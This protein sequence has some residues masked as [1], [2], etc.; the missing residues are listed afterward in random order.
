MPAPFVIRHDCI[1]LDACCLIN[2]HV[3]GHIQE[4][5]ECVPK[6]VA[7]AAYVKEREIKRF[8]LDSLI[9][10]KRIRVVNPTTEAEYELLT[11][12]AAV[13]DDG[14]AVTGAIALSRN[15]AI[16]TDDRRAIEVIRSKT[17]K[18]QIVSSLELIKNWMDQK[19]ESPLMIQNV[20]I[21]LKRDANYS[22][23]H[24]HEL[25]TWWKTHVVHEK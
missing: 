23:K 18:L 2:T 3:S 7:V 12:F 22:P 21:K 10:Q 11:N 13:M 6:S 1:I 4:I 17:G 24:D 14:E 8:S 5:L 19:R 25:Y 16:A 15:W 9:K 20:L